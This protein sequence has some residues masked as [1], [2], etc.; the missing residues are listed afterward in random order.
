MKI[1]FFRPKGLKAR[2]NITGIIYDF[3]S[4]RGKLSVIRCSTWF[5]ITAKS[6]S[7]PPYIT[8]FR[9]H[10]GKII[11]IL[12]DPQNQQNLLHRF[13]IFPEI[14]F[15]SPWMLNRCID[16]YIVY[17]VWLINNSDMLHVH[18]LSRTIHT[19]NSKILCYF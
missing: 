2:A 12:S 10:T 13:D 9:G 17:V 5:F 4:I 11:P 6:A 18:H 7:N 8:R 1:R 16:M 19:Q 3:F 15:K 14:F